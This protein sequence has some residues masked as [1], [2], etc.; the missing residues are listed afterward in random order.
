MSS[1]WRGV[2]DDGGGF[3]LA[4]RCVATFYYSIRFCTYLISLTCQI[5]SQAYI[6]VA[7]IKAF[8][9]G[10]FHLKLQGGSGCYS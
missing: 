6:A 3:D 7:Y 4:V 5:G 9:S 1:D 10:L 2:H 8:V